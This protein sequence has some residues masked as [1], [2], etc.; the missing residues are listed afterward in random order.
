MNHIS[1]DKYAPRYAQMGTIGVIHP[2]YIPVNHMYM[3]PDI[4]IRHIRK[5]PTC[6]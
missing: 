3:I 5:P 2:I 1:S 4:K 6:K